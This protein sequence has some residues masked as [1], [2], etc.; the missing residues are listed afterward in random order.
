MMLLYFI[1]V[2]VFDMNA[3]AKPSIS[4]DWLE[5]FYNTV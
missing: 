4:I 5:A 2:V 3:E 1:Q